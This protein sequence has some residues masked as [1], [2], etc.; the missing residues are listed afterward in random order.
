MQSGSAFGECQHQETITLISVI[1][2]VVKP[3]GQNPDQGPLSH[4]CEA[5]GPQRCSSARQPLEG[6]VRR[7][8]APL[9]GL[10]LTHQRGNGTRKKLEA[11]HLAGH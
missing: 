10:F 11:V 6:G 1:R 4:P 2:E 8:P 3:V 9:T 7:L 5:E